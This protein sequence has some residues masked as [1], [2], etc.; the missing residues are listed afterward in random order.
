MWCPL[1]SIINMFYCT[2]FLQVQVTVKSKWIFMILNQKMYKLVPHNLNYNITHNIPTC[3]G[4]Q[5]TIIME[6]NQSNTIPWFSV[7]NLLS[8]MNRMN[9]IKSI[10]IY[11]K[12]MNLKIVSWDEMRCHAD[13]RKLLVLFYTECGGNKFLWNVGNIVPH[14]MGITFQKTVISHSYKFICFYSSCIW[15]R[16]LILVCRQ[17][18]V[19]LSF[20]GHQLWC[21]LPIGSDMSG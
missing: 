17:D 2:C 19:F 11:W 3:F 7:V 15:N 16:T 1:H 10:W 14:N 21:I 13:S 4:L 8:I 5:G 18:W 9:N 20:H 12:S 6:S